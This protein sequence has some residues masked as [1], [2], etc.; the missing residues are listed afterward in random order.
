[1]QIRQCR[2]QHT[3]QHKYISVLTT[4]IGFSASELENF[5]L[6]SFLADK[7]NRLKVKICI[8]FHWLCSC[9]WAAYQ[10]IWNEK[11]KMCLQLFPEG[12]AGLDDGLECA[13]ISTQT[14]HLETERVFKN[15]SLEVC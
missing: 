3:V 8:D 5:F 4:G 2:I 1:M 7:Q 15:R 13:W 14:D 9:L 11:K 10:K 12:N 6:F